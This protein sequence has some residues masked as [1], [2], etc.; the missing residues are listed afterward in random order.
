MDKG[1]TYATSVTISSALSCVL[2]RSWNVL[3]QS[4]VKYNS[5]IRTNERIIFQHGRRHIQTMS[6][7][8]SRLCPWCAITMNIWSLSLSNF[9][10][11][12]G[13]DSFGCYA[14]LS[15]LEPIRLSPGLRPLICSSSSTLWPVGD[16]GLSKG[17]GRSPEKFRGSHVQ[18][19]SFWHKSDITK[20]NTRNTWQCLAYSPLGAVE[21]PPSEY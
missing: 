12:L 2:Q 6:W 17:G 16:R 13:I 4:L 18:L 14:I 19:C 1:V 11:K 20:P 15:P 10:L 3:K 5:A 7:T 21:S 8:D 9:W